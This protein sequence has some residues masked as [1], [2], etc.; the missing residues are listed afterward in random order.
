MR[1][2]GR[3]NGSC[4]EVKPQSSSMQLPSRQFLRYSLEVSAARRRLAIKFQ[5]AWLSVSLAI[6]LIAIS[7]GCLFALMASPIR[8]I[9]AVLILT[10][11]IRGGHFLLT[12]HH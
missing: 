10:A 9:A 1:I 5:L 3:F 8:V 4:F 7:L 12:R 2:D 6:V 11:G